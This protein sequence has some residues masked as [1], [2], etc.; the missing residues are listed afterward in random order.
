MTRRI[1]HVDMDAFY[2]AVEQAD[3]PE[4]KGCPVIVGGGVRGVVSAASY[5]ARKHG[6]RSAMPMFQARKLC[7]GGIF[8]PV[9]MRRYKEISRRIMGILR[10]FSPLVEQI[11]IDEAYL[12]ITGTEALLGSAT[13]VGGK[14]KRTIFD[15]TSLTCSVGI[16]PNRFL[17]KIA[18]EKNKPNGL[19][20]IEE[21]QVEEFLSGLPIERI[22]GIGAKTAGVFRELGA[23]VVGDI[24][25]FPPAF[26]VKRFGQYGLKIYEKA[27]GIDPSP[28]VPS[29]EPKSV[30][31]EDTF[32]QDTDDMDE[33]LRWLMIQAEGVG[34]D[35]RKK[36]YRGRTVTV[37]VKFSDFRSLTRSRT[38]DEPT[39][40]TETIFSVAAELLLELRVS[41]KLRLIGVGLSNL[42]GL[43]R[44]AMLF[45]NVRS[46]RDESLD[47]A[48]DE[49]HA[50]FG[51]TALKRGRVFKFEA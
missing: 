17:A 43:E 6:V 31:A 1:M 48:M 15:E 11:S 37:K 35:L 22:P 5:E 4:I 14:V 36:G 30:S 16:A 26:L 3:N 27:Q 46:C 45:E 9:R 25:R 41:K 2:A 40:C 24:L 13:V 28:V 47:R 49:I 44:Q 21:D 23:S 18:S 19:T 34:R 20:V 29:A 38:L 7:P 32:P 50:K 39:N 10:E 42:T 12:D 51:E 8:L 33:L